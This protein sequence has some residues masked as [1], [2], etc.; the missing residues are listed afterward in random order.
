MSAMAIL[1]SWP[2]SLVLSAALL[3]ACSGS[4]GKPH[5]SGNGDGDGAGDGDGPPTHTLLDGGGLGDGDDSSGGGSASVNECGSDNPAGLAVDAIATLKAGGSADSMRWLYP[6]DGTVFP[7]GLQAPL[8][9]WDGE[10]ADAVYVRIRSS[11][12]N[13]EGCLRPDAEGRVALSEDVW[14]KAGQVTRG[15]SDPFTVELSVLSGNSAHGPISQKIIIAQATL[16]GSIYYNSYNAGATDDAFGTGGNGAV[17]RIRPGQDAEV[18]ARA[19][20]CT[21]CHSV[22][23][24]GTR[25]VA[26]EF[27]G[28]PG[29]DDGQVYAIAPDTQPNPEPAVGSPA[30]A[31]VGLYP[32]GSVYLT[33]GARDNVGPELQGGFMSVEDR[34]A[35]L[36]E[37]DTGMPIAGSG[38]PSTALMPTFSPDGKLL[39]FN[40]Y[41]AGQGHAIALMDYEHASHKASGLRT[42]YKQSD[43]F[44]GWP[45]VL[46]DD[47]ALLFAYGESK[48]FDGQGA[49]IS[50]DQGPASDLSIVDIASG[51]AFALAQAVGFHTADDLANEQTY[52]PFGQDDVHQ[53]YFPVVSPVASGGYFWVFFDSMRHYGNFGRHRQLWGT[54]LT[55]S[56]DG[57]Y[58]SDPSHPAFYIGGQ[59]VNTA[60]HRAFT[61]LDPCRVNGD[62]C[63]TGIDCCGGRCEFEAGDEFHEHGSCS[64]T[65]GM[66]A[67]ENEACKVDSDCCAPPDGGDPYQCI[68]GFCATVGPVL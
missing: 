10:A 9:M 62:S 60:N 45:F 1:K 40:D 26:M 46:P 39:T 20:T 48:F 21:A 59:D 7:R 41:A 42:V 17:L 49:G 38:I 33:S 5:G 51:K 31:F 27:G 63:K 18:F 65:T 29:G 34:D 19:N 23:A 12:F 47:H 55:I 57:K 53:V 6:Y 4:S 2:R 56:A 36:Y 68:A 13:Y 64:S 8:L 67:K 14:K 32:D 58:K 25:L 61:A 50:L 66:C 44:L 54:A 52:L 35:T 3:L 37:T 43:S 30:A 16:S 15:P 11:H 28:S 24:N 22:S